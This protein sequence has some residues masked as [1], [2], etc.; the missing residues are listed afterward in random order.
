MFVFYLFV[1]FRPLRNFVRLFSV[2]LLSEKIKYARANN[3]LLLLLLLLKLYATT[4]SGWVNG[5]YARA[6]TTTTLNAMSIL[7]SMKAPSK[8]FKYKYRWPFHSPNHCSKHFHSVHIVAFV[9]VYL[10]EK[11]IFSPRKSKIK[12]QLFGQT[13]TH[14][15]FRFDSLFVWKQKV[16]TKIK[17]V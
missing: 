1:I 13:D 16:I 9:L 17:L 7:L 4:Q 3:L 10:F 15:E 2:Y 12:T 11:F 14:T 8:P 5:S 6:L